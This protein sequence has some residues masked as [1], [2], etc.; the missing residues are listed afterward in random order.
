MGEN[1]LKF[2][3]NC[4]FCGKEVRMNTKDIIQFIG[5]RYGTPDGDQLDE[6]FSG[7]GINY[8][9]CPEC[10]RK[11]GFDVDDFEGWED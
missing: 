8:N 4:N 6:F 11:E 7:I 10:S 5:S 1:D 3:Y 2:K 9:L